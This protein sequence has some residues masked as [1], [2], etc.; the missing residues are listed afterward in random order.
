MAEQAEGCAE[1]RRT[2]VCLR[3]GAHLC[4]ALY[5][6]STRLAATESLQRKFKIHKELSDL[7]FYCQAVSFRDFGVSKAGPYQ[8]MSSWPEKKAFSVIARSSGQPVEF[9]EYNNRQL[10]RVYPAGKRVDS[11]NYDPLPLWCLGSQLVALN[12]QTPGLRLPVFAPR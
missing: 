5:S 10:S 2:P 9:N 11:S 12:F 7:I 8:H 6:L 3:V 4:C 1:E